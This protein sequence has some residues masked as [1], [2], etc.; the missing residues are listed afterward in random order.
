M[1]NYKL[2]RERED[3]KKFQLR[4]SF[5]GLAYTIIYNVCIW[6]QSFMV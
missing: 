5:I 6:E 4:T 3:K 2:Q 1:K